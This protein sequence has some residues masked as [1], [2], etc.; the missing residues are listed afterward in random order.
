M[1]EVTVLQKLFLTAGPRTVFGMRSK[2]FCGMNDREIYYVLFYYI[3]L[4]QCDHNTLV[5]KAPLFGA[6]D[7][8]TAGGY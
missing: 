3:H 2:C 7:V 1:P 8:R 5:Y 4:L 6:S